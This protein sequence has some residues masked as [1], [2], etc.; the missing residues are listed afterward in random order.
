[1]GTV[2][3][4]EVTAP[5]RAAALGAIQAAFDS[6]SAVDRVLSTWRDDSD[7]ARLNHAAPG[8]TVALSPALG[9]LLDE[10]SRWSRRTDGAFDPAVGSLVDAWDLRGR[11]RLP[12]PEALAAARRT[13]GLGQFWFGRDDRSAFRRSAGAWLDTGG[14]GKGVALRAAVAALRSAGITAGAINFGGQVAVLGGGP[15]GS[16]WPVPVADPARRSVPAALL[17]VRDAS[18]STSGQSERFVVIGKHRFGHIL[19][20]R[21]GRPAPAWGSVTVVAD[22]PA[23]ADIL[24]TALFVLGPDAGLTWAERQGDVAALFLIRGADGLELRATRALRAL[25][26]TVPST[27]SGG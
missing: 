22:D 15:D 19:D 5:D 11:G 16:G 2:L 13:A 6:V 24:S 12:V 21:T 1:M 18:V 20:P 7:I 8:D 4:A 3:R 23:V 17:R 9:R 26:V 10:A 14:F 27:D 25:L